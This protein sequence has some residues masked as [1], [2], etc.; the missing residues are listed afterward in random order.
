[1]SR[2]VMAFD[3]MEFRKKIFFKLLLNSAYFF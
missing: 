3:S 1:M 2:A